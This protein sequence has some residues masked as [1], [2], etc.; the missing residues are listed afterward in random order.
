MGSA[1]VG[2]APS[3][4]VAG[5][6]YV[7]NAR[8]AVLYLLALLALLPSPSPLGGTCGVVGATLTPVHFGSGL[9]EPKYVIAVNTKRCAAPNPS[10]F[11]IS[12]RALLS[13]ST[14]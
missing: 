13:G 1:P 11:M 14:V 2:A 9:G 3:R 6:A 7:C 8:S 5:A 4:R 10:A 12:S